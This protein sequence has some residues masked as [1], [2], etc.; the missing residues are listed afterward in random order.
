[1]MK[2]IAHLSDLH[3][4]C[5]DRVIAES[6]RHEL[7]TDL[8]DVIAISGDLTQRAK[9]AEFLA[10][11]AYFDSLHAPVIVVPGNHDVPFFNLVQ[12]FFSPLEKYRKFISSDPCPF[13][14]D[15]TLAIAGINTAHGLTIQDG[16]V[17]EEQR[18]LIDNRFSALP[19]DLFRVVMMHHPI[20]LDTATPIDL[21]LTGHLH[22]SICRR[23]AGSHT[24]FVNAGTSISKR[25]R[26]EPNAYN[27][28]T[29][30]NHVITVTV[31]HWNGNAFETV[32]ENSTEQVRV[33]MQ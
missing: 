33:K 18:A 23:L 11:R 8:P 24:L 20:K 29:I 7:N 28:I 3:F 4:G 16:R 1:M 19:P 2:R 9:S 6:L 25:T 12:R 31:R 30:D 15:D 26:R 22:K 21:M 13:Y 5:E 14:S 32:S 10:A 17:L 27:R